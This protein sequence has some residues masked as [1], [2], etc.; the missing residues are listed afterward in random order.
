MMALSAASWE[1]DEMIN[2]TWVP[3]K[4]IILGYGVRHEDTYDPKRH[5]AIA[6]RITTPERRKL[7]CLL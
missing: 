7:F 2:R 4:S 1:E 5:A 3:R 6:D